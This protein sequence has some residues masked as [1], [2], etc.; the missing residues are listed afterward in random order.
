MGEELRPM[1]RLLAALP[2][3]DAAVSF[4][5][6]D[7][8]CSLQRVYFDLYAERFPADFDRLVVAALWSGGEGSYTMQARIVGPGGEEIAVGETEMEALPPTATN[9]QLVYFY[10]LALPEPG[11]Y[12]VQV[13]LDGA[14]VHTF[15]LHVIRLVSPEELEGEAEDEGEEERDE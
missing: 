2:C 3:E 10:P 8:R 7:R 1:P 4:G 9:T 14:E 12:T 15:P 13:L 5:V 11:P 6:Y